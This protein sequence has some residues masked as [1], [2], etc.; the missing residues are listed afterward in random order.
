MS[1]KEEKKK[2]GKLYFLAGQNVEWNWSNVQRIKL[3]QSLGCPLNRI[4]H[5]QWYTSVC[6]IG[7]C[8]QSEKWGN[9]SKALRSIQSCCCKGVPKARNGGTHKPLLCYQGDSVSYKTLCT[10]WICSQN[11]DYL[12]KKGVYTFQGER[13]GRWDTSS[14][15]VLF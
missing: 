9:V 4:A 15:P 5:E 8:S 12:K 11:F 13:R 6:G 7:G 3:L 14:F 1:W 2:K 10:V